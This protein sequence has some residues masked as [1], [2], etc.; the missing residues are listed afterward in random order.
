MPGKSFKPFYKKEVSFLIIS[1]ICAVS[2]FVLNDQANRVLC[3]ESGM[4]VS[5]TKKPETDGKA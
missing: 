3:R 2:P 4:P 5:P 1:F